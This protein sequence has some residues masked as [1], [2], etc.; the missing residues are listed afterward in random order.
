M[1]PR[2]VEESSKISMVDQHAGRGTNIR[3]RIVEVTYKV[4][5]VPLG[6]IFRYECWICIEASKERNQHKTESI[7]WCRAVQ[8]RAD[9]RGRVMQ[10]QS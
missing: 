3:S 1:G 10:A 9:R 6:Y 2:I 5:L 7:H 8:Q 4:G